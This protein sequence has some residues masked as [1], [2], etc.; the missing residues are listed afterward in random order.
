MLEVQT[1]AN[2]MQYIGNVNS[3]RVDKCDMIVI[4][5]CGRTR[6]HSCACSFCCDMQQQVDHL[7]YAVCCMLCLRFLYLL[8]CCSTNMAI[9][10]AGKLGEAITKHEGNLEAALE[11]YQQ[12]RVAQTAKEACPQLMTCLT[13]NTVTCPTLDI[14]TS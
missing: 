11:E 10:D 9:A 6:M 12:E 1:I 2:D 3:L 5:C 14:V 4:E 7:A 8:W 13:L